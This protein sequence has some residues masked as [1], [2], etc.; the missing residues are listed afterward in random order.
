MYRQIV[1]EK[2]KPNEEEKREILKIAE[3]IVKNIN[4]AGYEAK[5]LGSVSRDTWL[6]YEKDLDI[7]VFLE[8]EKSRDEIKEIIKNIGEKVLERYEMRFAQ[9]PYVRGYYKGY[10]V[11]IVPCYKIESTKKLKSAVDRTPFHDS[12]VKEHINGKQDEVRLLKQ[13]LKGIGIYGAEA[14]VQGFSGYLCELLII[15]F[16]SFEN[17]LENAKKWKF[18][19]FLYITEIE[20]KIIEHLRERF[21]ND[22][23]VFI[24]P[25]DVR[26]N[27]ASA[28]SKENFYKF[29]YAAKEFLKYDDNKKIKFFF[30]NKRKADKEEV[31]RKFKERGTEVVAVLFE[32]PDVV[33]DILYPQLRKSMK[34]IINAIK[35]ADFKLVD[36]TFF[37]KNKVMLLFEV[38]SLRIPSAKLHK[39]PRVNSLNEIRFL[40]KY[41]KALESLCKPFIRDDSWFVYLRRRY[42]NIAIYLKRFLEN[43]LKTKGIAS[44]VAE[45]LS[46]GFIILTNED[47]FKDEFLDDLLNYFDPIFPWEA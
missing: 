40:E 39:G 35:N 36:S 23:L 32:K 37:V 45:A 6:K 7:F 29:I 18:N 22:A 19:E 42:T 13:F 10:A 17:L 20:D 16:G 5:L 2:I 15:K 21:K 34:A 14:K 12:F 44:H 26:R 46:K 25:T 28:L 31:L 9:H 47:A 3:E 43:N 11:E 4:E 24:D 41:E 8:E 27:V 38:E 33:D 30:P 1:L